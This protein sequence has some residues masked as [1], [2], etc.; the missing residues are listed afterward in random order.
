MCTSTLTRRSSFVWS[1]PVHQLHCYRDYYVQKVEEEQ[2]REEESEET[3]EQEQGEYEE[4]ADEGLGMSSES[5]EDPMHSICS[6]HAVLTQ[7]EQ[8]EEE[9]SPVLQDVLMSQRHL[10]LPG[11]EEV[12]ALALLLLE[13]ADNSD[14]HL[15]PVDLRQK[16]AT[17]ASSLQ[18]HDKTTNQSHPWRS[19]HSSA[20]HELPSPSRPSLQRRRKRPTTGQ[21]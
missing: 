4:M 13:L 20:H 10:H 18:E 2:S 7:E 17:A 3:A 19:R 16:I 12:K 5:E 6:K 1:V 11:I 14:L 8:V 9:D 15:V 21:Q